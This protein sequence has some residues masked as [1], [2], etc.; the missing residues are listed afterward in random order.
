[1][2]RDLHSASFFGFEIDVAVSLRERNAKTI[3]RKV[4][5]RW[6]SVQA[7]AYSFKFGLDQSPLFRLLR[8]VQY[9]EDEITRLGQL[10]SRSDARPQS[11]QPSLPR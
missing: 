6:F 1:M 5:L 10:S 7:D 2:E 9:H 4:N 8:G 11:E 3:G